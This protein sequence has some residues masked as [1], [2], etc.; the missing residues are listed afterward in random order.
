MTRNAQNL[1]EAYKLLPYDE[2][3]LFYLKK[4]ASYSKLHKKIEDSLKL[5]SYY[6]LRN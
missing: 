2:L 3:S 1:Y 4:V 6:K 5:A